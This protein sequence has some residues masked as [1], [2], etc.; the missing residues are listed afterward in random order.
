LKTKNVIFADLDGTL[1]DENYD[2][3]TTKPIVDKLANLDASIVFCSSKTRSE[4]E[5]YRNQVCLN[6]PFISENGAAIYI[7]KGYFPFNYTCTTTPQYSTIKLGASYET[8]RQKL[9]YISHVT[10]SQILGFGDMT[11]HEIA[12]DAGLTLR[13]A[14]LAKKR[15]HDEP[16]KLLFGNKKKILQAIRSEGLFCTEGGRYFHLTGDTDKGKAVAVLRELYCRMFGK[17]ETFGIGD[18]PNDLSMLNV[19]DNPFFIKKKE[20]FNSGLAWNGIL[21]FVATKI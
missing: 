7:P 1:L 13:L 4:I 8:L 16:F 12:R 21:Q 9:A 10:A 11:I 5:Y 18:G 19:V 3:K 2:Y 17:V 6:E 20:G 14:R 15:E